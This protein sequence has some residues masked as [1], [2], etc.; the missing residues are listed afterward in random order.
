MLNFLVNSTHPELSH[1]VHQCARYCENPRASHEAAVKHVV[2]YLLSTQ[3]RNGRASPRYGLNMCPDRT[4]GLEVY[5]DASFAGDW[6]QSWSEEQASVLSRTGYVI[7][8][9][10]CPIMWASKLQTEITLSST[11]AEYV[12]LSQAMREVIPL[13]NLLNEIKGSIR[14]TE[15][16]RPNFRCTV[17]EDNNGCIELAKCPRMRPRTKHIAVKYH[18]F[19]SKVEEGLI[20]ILGIDTKEQQADLLTKNL[21][22]DQFLK[23]WKL[24]CGW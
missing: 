16:S 8:Y 2:R 24:I 12:A 17:F 7:K 15:Q 22:K 1:A 3:E 23:F 13:M 6:N 4:R 5:V 21:A 9:A 19:R 18:H 14:I 10:N 20:E 11:E